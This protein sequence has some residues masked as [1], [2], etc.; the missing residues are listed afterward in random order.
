MKGFF[1]AIAVAIVAQFAVGSAYAGCGSCGHGDKK[2]TKE[3][4]AKKVEMHEAMA[5]CLKDGKSM[6]DCHKAHAKACGCEHC[7]DG[8]SCADCKHC[9]G[10]GHGHGK[11]CEKCDHEGHGHDH[12]KSDK[13]AKS[14]KK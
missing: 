14:K 5:K 3:E 8:K 4:R 11:T 6:A 10:K 7:K 2:L 12:G 1:L 9:K 13:E